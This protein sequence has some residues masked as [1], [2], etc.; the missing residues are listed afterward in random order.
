MVAE[1]YEDHLAFVL[2]E[3]AVIA[4]LTWGLSDRYT[5]FSR[6][7]P[8]KDKASVRTLP[9]DAQLERLAWNAIARLNKS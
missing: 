4:V 6:L 9:L 3:P 5:W 8:R 2:D 1:A 7:K